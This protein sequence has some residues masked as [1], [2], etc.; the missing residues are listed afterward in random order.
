MRCPSPRGLRGRE[1]TASSRRSCGC[2]LKTTSLV[3]SNREL[4][5]PGTGICQRRHE[6]LKDEAFQR[7]NPA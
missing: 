5:N 7:R 1:E 3:V 4:Q 2:D 6:E